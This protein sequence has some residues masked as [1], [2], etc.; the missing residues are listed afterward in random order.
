M[1]YDDGLDDIVHPEVRAH[2]N[3]LVSAVRLPVVARR[4]YVEGGAWLT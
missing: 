2:I 1:E 4:R 3:S